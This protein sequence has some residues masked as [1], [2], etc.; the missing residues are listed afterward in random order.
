MLY[1]PYIHGLYAAIHIPIHRYVYQRPPQTTDVTDAN[2]TNVT[3]ASGSSGGIGN[4]GSGDSSFNPS[5]DRLVLSKSYE[6]RALSPTYRL[7]ASN[8][9]QKLHLNLGDK[10][11]MRSVQDLAAVLLGLCDLLNDPIITL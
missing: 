5:E 7:Q 10:I 9:A 4:S 1:R 2:V 8:F 11:Y 6:P 3:D